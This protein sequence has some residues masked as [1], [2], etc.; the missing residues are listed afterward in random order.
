MN[1]IILFVILGLV[2]LLSSCF[3]V[4]PD[5]PF[6]PNSDE[7]A[8]LEIKVNLSGKTFKGTSHDPLPNVRLDFYQGTNLINSTTT[9]S[10]GDFNITLKNKSYRI[11]A[12]RNGWRKTIQL[13]DY[14][15]LKTNESVEIAKELRVDMYCW[16][17]DFDSY[18]VGSTPDGNP[19]DYSVQPGTNGEAKFTYIVNPLTGNTN[20][21]VPSLYINGND[22]NIAMV[23]FYPNYIPSAYGGTLANIFTIDIEMV[24]QVIHLGPF[25][26]N[27][28]LKDKLKAQ[29]RARVL[30]VNSERYRFAISGLTR[31]D[32]IWEKNRYSGLVSYGAA[33]TAQLLSMI[34]FN[35]Y[36]ENSGV[37]INA[38][39]PGQVKTNIGENNGRLYRFYKHY[40]VNPFSRSPKVSAKALY[41]L[42]VSSNVEGISG[43]FF[44]LTR[45]EE[46]APHALDKEVAEELWKESLK[47]GELE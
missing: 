27:Y 18:S 38:C 1:R 21:V 26:L 4:T 47:L 17:E 37:T 14:S 7:Y 33:K 8:N 43:K 22:D 28:M 42:G 46:L 30:F 41:Y 12:I 25:I 32:L 40:L 34:K 9:D 31:D 36:F 39:H 45:E 13:V 29:Q 6:D 5:N 11:E 20:D 35:E 2:I 23:D 44:H 15:N 24:F 19:W 10:E 3:Q 16:Y